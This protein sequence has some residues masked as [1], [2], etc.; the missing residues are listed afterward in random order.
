MKKLLALC[1]MDLIKPQFKTLQLKIYY[2]GVFIAEV[3]ELHKKKK[4]I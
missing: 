1:R 3:I 2:S 4:T